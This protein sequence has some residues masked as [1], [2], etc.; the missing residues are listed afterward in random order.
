MSEHVAL[1]YLKFFLVKCLLLLS[2]DQQNF[3][4]S[5]VNECFMP[6]SI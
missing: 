3:T 4:S 5:K 2:F 6:F 1:M